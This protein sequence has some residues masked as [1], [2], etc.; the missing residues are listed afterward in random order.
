MEEQL[1]I[2]VKKCCICHRLFDINLFNNKHRCRYCNYH[3]TKTRNINIF[4][5]MY[6][7]KTDDVND[8]L[9]LKD[10]IQ[11]IYKYYQLYTKDTDIIIFNHYYLNIYEYINSIFNIY[12]EDGYIYE[13]Y[14]S[15]EFLEKCN[16]KNELDKIIFHKIKF[17]YP[18]EKMKCNKCH[19]DYDKN[20]FY[21]NEKKIFD[22]CSNC[23]IKK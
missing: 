14:F 1:T 18:I 7:K 19:K 16:S 21:N 5:L 13:N 3:M 4:L 2:I 17:N 11:I 9:T 15:T 8:I 22:K 20:E 23:R 12:V 6:F 10:I